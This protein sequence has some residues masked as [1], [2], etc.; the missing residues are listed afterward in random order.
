MLI[1]PLGTLLAFLFIFGIGLAFA[2][3][4]FRPVFKSS[5]ALAGGACIVL[6][7][8]IIGFARLD[9]RIGLA[10]LNANRCE[11]DFMMACELPVFVLALLSSKG[12][13]W[14]FWLGWS[15]NLGFA[16]FAAT[17]VIWLEFFWHW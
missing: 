6:A 1:L 12:C 4:L 15:I 17:I 5:L 13:R 9:P 2:A 16:L 7:F 10:A 14:A 11:Y 3:P 8:A